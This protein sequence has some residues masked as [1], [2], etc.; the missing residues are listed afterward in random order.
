MKITDCVNRLPPVHGKSPMKITRR[1]ALI[2]LLVLAMAVVLG[3]SSPASAG[4][5]KPTQVKLHPTADSPNRH[6]TGT[7][8]LSEPVTMWEMYRSVEVSVSKLAPNASYYM[9]V[10]LFD[11][12]GFPAGVLNI[13]IQTDA[14]GKGQRGFGQ[15]GYYIIPSFQVYDASGTL[16]LTSNP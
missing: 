9:P 13:P 12:F 11:S 6:A 2:A 14:R 10:T 7:V 1:F 8:T 3:A 4:A 15:S 16:V 5:Q